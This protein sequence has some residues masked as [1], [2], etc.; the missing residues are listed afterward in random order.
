LGPVEV[1]DM[2]LLALVQIDGISMDQHRRGKGVAFAADGGLW[3]GHVDNH[4]VLARRRTLANPLCRVFHATPLPGISF[5]LER[6]PLLEP[7]EC[8]LQAG[9]ILLAVGLALAKRQ[10]EGGAW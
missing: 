5:A 8:L 4:H 9:S 1:D 10:L 3:I 7:L 6:L 2:V